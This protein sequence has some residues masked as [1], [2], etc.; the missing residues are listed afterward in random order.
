MG[1]GTAFKRYNVGTGS[2]NSLANAPN[3]IKK[4]GA[5]TTDGTN[6]YVLRGDTHKEF[7]RYNV[8]A[9]TW[10]TLAPVPVNVAWGGS[11]T[12]IGGSIYALSGD[13]KK[14]FYRYNI[15][16]NTLDRRAWRTRRRATWRTAAR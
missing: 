12:Y 7:F 14:N 5:L 3:N 10:T 9:N 1:G 13:G 2:W 15:A 8:V 16:A 4:G 11:L 6:I